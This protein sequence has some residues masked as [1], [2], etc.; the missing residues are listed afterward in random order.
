[1]GG[2]PTSVE[3]GSL[4]G[5]CPDLSHFSLM[6]MTMLRLNVMVMTMVMLMV[7]V[8]VMTMVMMM[9]VVSKPERDPGLRVLANKCN[10][11]PANWS[12]SFERDPVMIMMTMMMM[13]IRRIRKNVIG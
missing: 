8:M 13:M 10:C 6:I 12:A 1:M 3:A 11:M 9:M 7:M 5:K 2:V 4:D